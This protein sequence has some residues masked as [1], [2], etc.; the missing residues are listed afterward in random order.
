MSENRH[1]LLV[2]DDPLIV[3][4]LAHALARP[5]P[6][7]TMIHVCDGAEALDYLRASGVFHDRPPGNPA[8]VLLDLKMPRIDGLEVL[9]QIK[10]DPM[11]CHIPVVML[12]SSR[13][14]RDVR[15]SY[16][17]GASAYVVKP[18]DFAEF[19]LVARQLETF[20][21]ATN[22]PPPGPTGHAAAASASVAAET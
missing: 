5:F 7:G 12:T 21:L 1:L 14:E 18:L 16:K 15:A 3:E 2:D 20:W 19:I 13:E 11:L 4:L 10:A 22:V 17:L 8:V 9:R 6:A